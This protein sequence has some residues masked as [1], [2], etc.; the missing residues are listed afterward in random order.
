MFNKLF[1]GDAPRYFTV[2][3]ALLLLVTGGQALAALDTAS[4]LDFTPNSPNAGE[5]IITGRTAG[6]TATDITIPATVSDGG[7]L[8][9]WPV[10]G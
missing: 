10:L 2:L 6:N 9:T 8:I 1:I 7:L 4:G 5:A 3:F